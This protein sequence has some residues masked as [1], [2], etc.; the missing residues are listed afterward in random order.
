MN[1]VDSL[2]KT[3]FSRRTLE[4]KIKIKSL[5]R[6][7]PDL[8]IVQK[9][10]GSK[11]S[12]YTRKF[13][14]TVYDNN[15]WICGCEI[16]NSLFCFPC[17][18]FGNGDSWSKTGVKDLSHMN[19]YIKKHAN[20]KRHI[21][22]ALDLCT[23]GSVN[24]ATQLSRAYQESILKHNEQVERNRYILSKIIDCVKF[25]GAFEL[26]L[27]GHDETETSDNPGV[28]LGLINL[29]S[30]VDSIVKEHIE[31]NKVFKGTSKLIQNDLLDC[32][33]EVCHDR[34]EQEL[35][36]ASYVS[37]MADETS[38]VAEKVQLA[39]VYRYE[40]NGSIHERF[41]GFFNPEDQTANSIAECILKQL[42]RIFKDDRRKIIAQTYDGASVMSGNTGGVQTKV[43]EHYPLAQYVHCYAHQLNLIMEKAASQNQSARV[44]F[45]SLSAFP[46]FF[47]RSPQ[48]VA[49]LEAVVARKVPG[50]S[51]TRW[52]FK[53]RTVNMI[54]EHRQSLIDCFCDL[55]SSLSSKTVQEARGLR[56]NL[57]DEE[58]VFWLTFFQKIMPHVDILYNQLQARQIDAVRAQH[59]VHAFTS[60]VEK[61]RDAT[62][63]VAHQIGTSN[64]ELTRKRRRNFHFSTDAKE[65]CDRITTEVRCRFESTEHL[66]AAKLL[67]SQNFELFSKVFPEK[68]LNVVTDRH[69]ELDKNRLRTELS[70]LYERSDFRQIQGALPLLQ[71]ILKNNLQ[72]TLSEVTLV[73]KILVTIPMSTAEPERCFSSL[74]RIKTFLRNTMSQ[75]RLTAL[76]MLSI[77]KGLVTNI[78]DFNTKVIEKF[79][80]KKNRR[81]DFIF[82]H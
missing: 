62:D 49:A 68:E 58:F 50:G 48:R 80:M 17:L 32:M 10:K 12:V 78:K 74:N 5:G 7:T 18:L 3:P 26:A 16:R 76:A 20:S 42:D 64:E 77:E 33:L 52:N 45:C 11:N 39:I 23:L 66:D 41:W 82:R 36:E 73:V 28:F 81:M 24:I 71:L 59:A 4:D 69:K 57:E 44:F 75:D 37:I 53:S 6:L 29:I 31:N 46:A 38:D 67:D 51:A 14:R 40:I 61:V 60:A 15:D 13:N 55:E 56:H 21:T 9:A 79:C 43:K 63:D 35:K 25:C 27:R 72:T 47:S 70:I 65:V 54:Y 34:I 8:N 22:N 2:L 19:E 30:S 1:S